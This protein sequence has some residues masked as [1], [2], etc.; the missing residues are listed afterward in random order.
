MLLSAVHLLCTM[1]YAG[2]SDGQEVPFRKNKWRQSIPREKLPLKR[3]FSRFCRTISEKSLESPCRK[4]PTWAFSD[5]FWP[6]LALSN[7]DQNK[8]VL[9]KIAWGFI[10]L[11][12]KWRE[13]TASGWK[14]QKLV[15]V[16]TSKCEKSYSE[17]RYRI[18]SIFFGFLVFIN[19]LKHIFFVIFR[20]IE[21]A[22]CS[23]IR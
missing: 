18:D 17:R 19:P 3:Y 13:W 21:F 15:I 20:D 11:H 22:T 23:G 16:N 2:S 9:C 12:K 5:L 4:M 14:V 8:V 7:L 6:E 1:K 10:I